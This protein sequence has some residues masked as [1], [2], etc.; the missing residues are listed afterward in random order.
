MNTARYALPI[1]LAL[2]ALH[3]V[4]APAPAPAAA[5]DKSEFLPPK[6]KAN[7][8]FVQNLK[9]DEKM[10]YTVFGTDLL[11]VAKLGGRQAEVI[12]MD[13]GQYS[14]YVTSFKTRRIDVEMEAGRTYFVMLH[15]VEKFGARVSDIT[16]VRRATETYLQLKSRLKGVWIVHAKDDPCHGKS[17]MER[18][19]RTQKRANEGNSD[20]K[21]G[22]DA[23]RAWYTLDKQDGLLPKDIDWL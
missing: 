4:A 23:N 22:N 15:T 11:C 10:S 17:L 9:V 14:F 18:K 20:W 8:V 5:Y 2:L 21:A 16:L 12:P 1:A 3:A 19:G 6:G 13:P 7:I